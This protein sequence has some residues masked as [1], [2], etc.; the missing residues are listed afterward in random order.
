M[1]T[2]G[3]LQQLTIFVRII[4]TGSFTRAARELGLSPSAVSKS[5]AKLETQLETQLIKRGSRKLFLTW[6]GEVLFNQAL[7]LLEECEHML[8][9]GRASPDQR[10]IIKLS[11]PVAWGVEIL[12]P[13]ISGYQQ[14]YPL[15][16]LHIELSDQLISFAETHFDLA[17]RITRQMEPAENKTLLARVHWI[18]CCSP[19]YLYGK[20]AIASPRDVASHHCL[21]NPMAAYHNSWIFSGPD[22][23]QIIPV[24]A[25]ITARSSLVLLR[26]LLRHGGISCLPDYLVKPYIKKGVLVRLFPGINAGRSHYLYAIQRKNKHGNPLIG[27]F[28]DY[29]QQALR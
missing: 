1:I 17:L 28:I 27:S 20:P 26:I 23:E 19:D 11:C 22:G 16:S 21:S 12:S 7:A 15:T 5:L 8:T 29:L 9:P 4:I 25:A 18:Y 6:R 13:L 10:N 2:S 14:A 3:T 24:N